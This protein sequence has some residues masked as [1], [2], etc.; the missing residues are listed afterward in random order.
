M[1]SNL[2]YYLRRAAEERT[3]ANRSVTPQA[4]EWHS[5]LAQQFAERAQQSMP[6]TMSA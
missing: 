2:R 5:Q 1:E 6:M 4:K 3:A